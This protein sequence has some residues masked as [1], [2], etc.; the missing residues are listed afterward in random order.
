MKQK[1]FLTLDDVKRIAAAYLP[2]KVHVHRIVTDIQQPWMSGYRRPL[3]WLDFW[4]YV[5]IDPAKQLAQRLLA[6][7]VIGLRE[8]G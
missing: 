4:P 1:P 8:L 2:W 3:F 6:R 5:D 7:R